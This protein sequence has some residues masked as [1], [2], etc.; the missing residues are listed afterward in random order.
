MK[1]RVLLRRFYQSDT[2]GYVQHG[3]PPHEVKY[4]AK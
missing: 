2:F 4:P 1:R 3:Q